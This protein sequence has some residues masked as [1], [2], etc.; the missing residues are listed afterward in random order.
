MN[1]PCR[2]LLLDIKGTSH[3]LA[4]DPTALRERLLQFYGVCQ[5]TRLSHSVALLDSRAYTFSDTFMLTVFKH[6]NEVS[7]TELIKIARELIDS[8]EHQGMKVR[9]FL[10]T[11][12]ESS[13]DI[14]PP[15]IEGVG[16]AEVRHLF[17]VNTALI[18]ADLGEHSHLPG[19]LFADDIIWNAAGSPTC[20]TF[21]VSAEDYH[22]FRK[23]NGNYTSMT[24][25]NRVVKMKGR[26]YSYHQL[27][28]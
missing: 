23:R 20:D 2:L 17:G 27:R 7:S 28:S 3:L 5:N 22:V 16:D 1:R 18:T 21:A 4:A 19:T 10:T 13:E 9:G 15:S 11:G 12:V 14:A 24:K 8:C 6:E 26:F 25:P